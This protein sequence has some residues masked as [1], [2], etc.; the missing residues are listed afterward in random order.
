MRVYAR[1][2]TDCVPS[3]TN[4]FTNLFSSIIVHKLTTLTPFYWSQI[5]VSDYS[6][7]PTTKNLANN[8]TLQPG[9]PW[10]NPFYFLHSDT[11]HKDQFPNNFTLV[12]SPLFIR[13]IAIIFFIR[14]VYISLQFVVLCC[15]LIHLSSE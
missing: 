12:T 3:S 4:A 14:L 8:Q 11:D 15:Q 13:Q 1:A 6:I 5:V 9:D 10:D 7:L 2:E